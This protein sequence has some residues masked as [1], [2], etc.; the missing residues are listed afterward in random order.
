VVHELASTPVPEAGMGDYRKLAVWVK[1]HALAL[2]VYRLTGAFPAEERYGLAAQLR[3]AVVSIA[4]NIVEG[5]GRQS[6]GDMGRFLQM[7]RGSLWELQAQLQ[8]ARDLGYVPG[9]V[10]AR[11]ATE[12]DEVGRMLVGLLG[13]LRRSRRGSSARKPAGKRTSRGQPG[14]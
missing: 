2:E 1:A 8:L 12:V 10:E 7:A 11:L 14:S 4:S 9:A 3:R 13:Y 6:D 5:S